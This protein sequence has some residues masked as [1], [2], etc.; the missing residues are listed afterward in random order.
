MPEK[1]KTE[2]MISGKAVIEVVVIDDV[3]VVPASSL[4]EFRPDRHTLHK[5][6]KDANYAQ[7]LQRLDA[8]KNVDN[9]KRS[10]YFDYYLERLRLDRP[11][12]LI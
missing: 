3:W 4:V 5:C 9:Y 7:M 2:F 10:P 8:G 6:K 11:E 1:H 12:Y